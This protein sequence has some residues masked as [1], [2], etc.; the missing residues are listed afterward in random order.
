MNFFKT[1]RGKLLIVLASSA[2]GDARL[3]ILSQFVDAGGKQQSRESRNGLL[4]A[5]F[6][7]GI[8]NISSR[9]YLEDLVE[10]RRSTVF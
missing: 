7:L 8:N 3:S 2:R 4:V 9:E 5:G 10:T 1:F 6:A